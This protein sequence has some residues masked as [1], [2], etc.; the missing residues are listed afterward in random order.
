MDNHKDNTPWELL[1]PISELPKSKQKH[2]YLVVDNGISQA[3]LEWDR[4]EY[5]GTTPRRSL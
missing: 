2:L 1:G 3:V 4:G 5:L